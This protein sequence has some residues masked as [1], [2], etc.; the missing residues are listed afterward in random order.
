MSTDAALALAASLVLG[1]MGIALL[2]A[3]VLW[4]TRQL[5]LPA[6]RRHLV[7]RRGGALHRTATGFVTLRRYWRQRGCLLF[8]RPRRFHRAAPARTRHPHST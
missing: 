8:Q 5:N 6:I 7:P 1:A 3:A 4:P 2:V